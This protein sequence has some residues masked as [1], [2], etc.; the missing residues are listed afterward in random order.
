MI[1]TKL[2]PHDKNKATFNADPG[3]VTTK[4]FSIKDIIGKVGEMWMQTLY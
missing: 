4:T 3:S 1:I 2:K